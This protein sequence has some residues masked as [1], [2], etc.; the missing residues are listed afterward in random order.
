[1]NEIKEKPK[2]MTEYQWKLYQDLRDGYISRI[3][4]CDRPWNGSLWDLLNP[5]ARRSANILVRK[6]YFTVDQAGYYYISKS[7]IDK[8]L[9]KKREE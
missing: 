2:D 8:S 9:A 6:G 1:M 4:F 3:S 5:N 7:R